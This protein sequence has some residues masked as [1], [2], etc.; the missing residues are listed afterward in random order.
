LD[1]GGSKY[2]QF[3][4]HNGG[5]DQKDN[6]GAFDDALLEYYEERKKNKQKIATND[7]GVKHQ[8]LKTSNDLAGLIAKTLGSNQLSPN[9]ED[10]QLEEFSNMEA[11]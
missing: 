5:K 4:V 9:D 11:V 7:D 10:E 6:G 3:L 2:L 8:K 1:C